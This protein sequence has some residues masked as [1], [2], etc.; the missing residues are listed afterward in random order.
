MVDR[1][2]GEVRGVRNRGEWN[3]IALCCLYYLC[4]YSN[5]LV[6]FPAVSFSF[7]FYQAVPCKLEIRFPYISVR[8]AYNALFVS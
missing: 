6:R 1:P 7:R 5:L 4:P 3:L 8:F 2:L